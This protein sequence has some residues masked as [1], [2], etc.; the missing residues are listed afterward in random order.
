MN[1]FATL[2]KIFPMQNSS[3]KIQTFWFKINKDFNDMIILVFHSR[4]VREFNQ[5]FKFIITAYFLWGLLT[6]SSSLLSLQRE[7]VKWIV[8]F[9]SLLFEIL[10]Q[11]LS[12]FIIFFSQSR[13]IHQYKS[14]C[15]GCVFL[16]FGL[17]LYCRSFL[18]MVK[19]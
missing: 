3:V 4:F 5:I 12:I 17:S 6:I 11:N 18:S 8:R 19:V 15:C 9:F 10:N 13:S 1:T 14:N 7:L 2:F 16:F